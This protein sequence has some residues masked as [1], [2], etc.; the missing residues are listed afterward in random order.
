MNEQNLIRSYRE[1]LL[2]LT[3]MLVWL[4]YLT[5]SMPPK[6]LDSFAVNN[7]KQF[8]CWEYQWKWHD[9]I[10]PYGSAD[11]YDGPERDIRR[12]CNMIDKIDG[13]SCYY[14]DKGSH[15]IKGNSTYLLEKTKCNYSAKHLQK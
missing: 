15:V 14:D 3:I 10:K 13:I 9:N 7:N 2:V 11:I 8:V 6:S 12:Q 4:L 1:T 5:F